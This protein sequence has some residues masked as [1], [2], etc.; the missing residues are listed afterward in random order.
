[1][2]KNQ[3]NS[4]GLLL[5]GKNSIS[6]KGLWRNVFTIKGSL[7]FDFLHFMSLN[8]EKLQII[9]ANIRV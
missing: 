9:Y 8:S 7:N 5:K 6:Y 3:N 4:N 1:M 2:N